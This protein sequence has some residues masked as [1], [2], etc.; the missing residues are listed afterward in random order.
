MQDL[1]SDE[2][3]DLFSYKNKLAYELYRKNDG[4]IS[5]KAHLINSDKIFSA[6]TP[7]N[8]RAPMHLDYNKIPHSI[9]LQKSTYICID[10][11][12]CRGNIYEGHK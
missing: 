9:S 3:R 1:I 11:D 7:L 10:D 5:L 4:M 6:L 2:K 12:I 8:S